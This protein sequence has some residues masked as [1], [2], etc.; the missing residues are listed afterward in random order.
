[1]AAGGD[2]AQSRPA[3]QVQAI[4]PIDAAKLLLTAGR[5]AEAEAVL[6]RLHAQA[7]RD[8]EV[9]FL[10]GLLA[11]A[12]GELSIAINRF[13][14]ILRDEPGN[15]RV[16]LELARA[17]FLK[18]D[19]ANAARQFQL[20]RA[21][22]LP[23]AVQKNVDNYLAVIRARRSW[24]LSLSLALAPDSNI[25]SAT[26]ARQVDIFGLPFDLSSNGRARSGAG[27]AIDAAGEWAPRVGRNLRFR[28]GGSID[29]LDYRDGAFDDTT[30]LAYA[31]P[32]W[33]LGRWTLSP[34]VTGAARWYGGDALSSGPGARLEVDGQPSARLHFS[35]ALERQQLTYAINPGQSGPLTAATADVAYALSPAALGHLSLNLARQDARDG[36]YANTLASLSVGYLREL[37][38]GFSVS[39]EP[40][41]ARAKYD[42]PLAAFGITRRDT[43]ARV[44]LSVLNR[45]LAF[46][47]FSPRLAYSYTA[48]WS[49][50]PLYSY[51]K[52]R[53]EVRLTRQF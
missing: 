23:P 43:I 18:G 45:Q 5:L 33:T 41:Y 8:R 7:P 51:R 46:K 11:E 12:R 9:L 3:S 35:A 42:A 10:M 1:M 44:S 13:R 21:G 30:L 4:S 49:S 16:R 17:F 39:I 19:D 28:L 22:K 36:A 52:S 40:G 32:S 34:V 37:P 50:V 47:G 27:L 20:A 38:R 25:N 15:P 14:D 31:G 6:E 48:D 26:A 29:S 24:S 2:Y 53:V